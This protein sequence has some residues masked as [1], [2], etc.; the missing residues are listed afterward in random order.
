MN[1]LLSNI[2]LAYKAKKIILGTDNIVEKM[3]TKKIKLVIM[4]AT[5][6]FNTQKLIQDKANTYGVDVLLL[7]VDDTEISHAIGRSNV[8]ILGINDVGFK[9][10][11][12]KSIE[13]RN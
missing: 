11:I 9:K 10:M 7:D 5:S 1:K 13:G 8:K 2:G 12:L 6:S 4:S 3:K